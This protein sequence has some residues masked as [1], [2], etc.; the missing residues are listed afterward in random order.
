MREAHGG[1]GL[2]DILTAGA[3]SPEGVDAD[4]RLVEFQV[5]NGVL[6]RQHGHGTDR[7]TYG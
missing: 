3:G 6:L 7:P 4:F 5:L 1:I 2:V